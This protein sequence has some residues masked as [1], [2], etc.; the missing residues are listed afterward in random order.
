[1]EYMQAMADA[2]YAPAAHIGDVLA[3]PLVVQ[4]EAPAP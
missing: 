2:L 3:T 1:M 4:V